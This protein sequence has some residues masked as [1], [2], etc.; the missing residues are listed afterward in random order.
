MGFPK[1]NKIQIAWG[2][3]ILIFKITGRVKTLPYVYSIILSNP[4][5]CKQNLPVHK[6]PGYSLQFVHPDI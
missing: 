2:D 5:I 6:L 1:G 4:H 3:V